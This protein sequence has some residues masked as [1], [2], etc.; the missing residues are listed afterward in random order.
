MDFP[1]TVTG[2]HIE[3]TDPLREH[4]VEKMD[5]ACRYLDK[6][7]SAHITFSVEKYRHIIEVVIQTHGTTLRGKEE[8]AD[9]Y[10]SIDQV[11]K[12]IESQ[13]KRLN[14]KIKNKKRHGDAGGGEMEEE[15]ADAPRV[16]ET[17][18][19]AAKPLTV[20]D[21]LSELEV[22]GDLFMVFRNAKTNEVNVLYRRKDGNYGL[23]RPH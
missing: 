18:A 4:A 22:S 8:T 9:M 3:V 16:I 14:E 11:M 5:N 12:K 15:P 2:R 7:T 20:D 23:V 19:F 1:I 10:S 17:E 13:A 21:A 6:I